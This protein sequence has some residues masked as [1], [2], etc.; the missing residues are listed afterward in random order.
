MRVKVKGGFLAITV[1]ESQSGNILL[2]KGPAK[3]VYVGS[4]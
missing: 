3:L 1:K 2:M 4:L